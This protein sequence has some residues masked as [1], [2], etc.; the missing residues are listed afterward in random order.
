MTTKDATANDPKKAQRV[1]QILSMIGLACQM[2]EP[3]LSNL[4]SNDTGP[5]DVAAKWVGYAG[6]CATAIG[7][8]QPVPLP[9]LAIF[10]DEQI[11]EL[12]AQLAKHTATKPDTLG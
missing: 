7:L 4:D 1:K 3:I 12:T 5:D 10:T 9:P 2:G 11:G 8:N 6:R